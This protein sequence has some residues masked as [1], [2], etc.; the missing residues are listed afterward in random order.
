[1][2]DFDDLLSSVSHDLPGCFTRALYD[3]ASSAAKPVAI[4]QKEVE[5]YDGPS[6]ARS[7]LGGGEYPHVCTNARFIHPSKAI[8]V[9]QSCSSFSIVRLVGIACRN[10]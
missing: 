7:G 8:Q 1:L 9:K 2:G 5:E 4:I 6:E 3:Q 10:S